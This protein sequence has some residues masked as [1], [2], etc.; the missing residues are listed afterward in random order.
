MTDCD[1]HPN[2]LVL[3]ASSDTVV[4]LYDLSKPSVKRSFRYLQVTP[5]IFFLY[6][7]FVPRKTSQALIDPFQSRT[8]ALPNR[9]HTRSTRYHSILQATSSLS[10]PNQKLSEST[11][12]K[13]SSASHPKP[14]PPLPHHPPTASLAAMILQPRQRLHNINTK[15]NNR[16]LIVEESIILNMHPRGRFSSVHRRMGRLKY[17]MRFQARL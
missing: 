5:C 17:G 15:C 16:D 4:K 7:Y 12:S 11:T 8:Y 1:F 6:F 10:D 2:G 14:S 13:L 9:T 3:A